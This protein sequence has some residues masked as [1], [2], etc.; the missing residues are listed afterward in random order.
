MVAERS[1][2]VQAVNRDRNS[3]AAI[4]ARLSLLCS[5]V[6]LGLHCHPAWQLIP[7]VGLCVIVY[8]VVTTGYS[9]ANLK[10]HTLPFS[11]PVPSPRLFPLLPLPCYHP[12]QDRSSTCWDI[13]LDMPILPVFNPCCNNF[14]FCP[15]KFRVYSTKLHLFLHDVT[16]LSPLLMRAF[17]WRYCNSSW[18]A[19]AKSKGGQYWRLQ[20]APKINYTVSKKTTLTLH[21]VTSMNM[22]RFH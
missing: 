18:N 19:R 13:R 12:S 14:N 3:F 22:N 1:S 10:I 20:T 21:T 4:L 9:R 16:T 8:V 6:G 5:V 15:R 17:A 2:G 11:H 7:V